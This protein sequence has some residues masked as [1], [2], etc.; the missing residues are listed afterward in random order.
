[1]EARSAFGFLLLLVLTCAVVFL[2]YKTYTWLN[3]GND[4][5]VTILDKP[6]K[7]E[8]DMHTCSGILPPSGNEHTYSFWTYITQ[9]EVTP[10]KPKYIFR[11]EHARYVLNVAVGDIH[12]ELQVFITDKASGDK[13]SRIG[14][15]GLDDDHTHRLTNLPLQAWNHIT[16]TIWNK[17]LD[18][19]LNGK[20]ARTF[21]LAKPLEAFEKG[22]FTIGGSSDDAILNGFVSRFQYFG[23]VVSPRDIYSI[24]M[25]GPANKSDLSNKPN[26]SQVTLDLSVG[27][28]P[29]CATAN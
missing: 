17:T 9:W 8:A 23:R 12:N 18:L 25:K 22:A 4:T 7:M 6:V 27:Q 13:V 28:T 3:K 26:S 21:V 15:L 1:M 29:E 20:L 2:I 16:I 5:D 19:Y 11:R 24:Y 14:E 10:S